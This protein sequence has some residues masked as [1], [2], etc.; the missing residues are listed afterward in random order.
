MALFDVCVIDTDAKS[1]VAH[2]PQSVLANAEKEKKSKYVNACEEKHASFTPLC[3]SVD[4]LLGNEVKSF[5]QRM[6]DRLANKWHKPY[7]TVN[8]LA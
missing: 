6:A 5:L 7:G 4:G 3:L 8:V 1:S 2:T